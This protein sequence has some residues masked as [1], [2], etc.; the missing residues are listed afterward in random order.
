MNRSPVLLNEKFLVMLCTSV[1][2]VTWLHCAL[3]NDEDSV[4]LS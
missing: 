1:I 3:K 2:C 4:L